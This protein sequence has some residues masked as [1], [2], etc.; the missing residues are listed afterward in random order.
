[1]EY[2]WV[3]KTSDKDFYLYD[4]NGRC[5]GSIE[6]FVNYSAKTCGEIQKV[7]GDFCDFESAR[8][9]VEKELEKQNVDTKAYNVLGIIF[10]VSVFSYIIYNSWESITSIIS[11][12][13]L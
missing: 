13:K 3:E 9:A 2:D 6:K 4:K 7:V 1:M 8:T 12:V 10:V 5:V 11:N